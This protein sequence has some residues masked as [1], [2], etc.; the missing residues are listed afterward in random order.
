MIAKIIID[1]EYHKWSGNHWFFGQTTPFALFELVGV[2]G[3]SQS[4][5]FVPNTW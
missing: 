1:S 4:N 3:I 5:V 2:T